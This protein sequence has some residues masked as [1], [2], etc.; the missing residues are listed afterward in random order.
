MANLQNDKIV[1]LQNGAALKVFYSQMGDAHNLCFEH[2]YV[3]SVLQIFFITL[4]W[5]TA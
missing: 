5:K 1:K 4:K 2:C 3:R